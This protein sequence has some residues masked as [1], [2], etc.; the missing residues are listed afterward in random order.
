MR[1][2]LEALARGLSGDTLGADAF[3]WATPHGR[4]RIGATGRR[5]RPS[6]GTP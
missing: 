2:A 4:G 6:P 1:G 5:P 3:P